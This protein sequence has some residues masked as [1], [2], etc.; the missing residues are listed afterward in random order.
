MTSNNTSIKNTNTNHKQYLSNFKEHLQLL[1]KS[2]NTIDSYMSDLNQYFSIYQEINR[3]N[4]QEYKIKISNLAA[5]SF[6]RKLTSLKQF[7]EYLLLERLI[8]EIV[9]YKQ[10]FI[11][12]QDKGNPTN[13]TESQVA[14]FLKKVNDKNHIYKSRN[15]AIIFLIANTGI[16][17]EEITNLL[18]KNLDLENGEL[19]LVKGKGNKQRVIL[20]NDKA[21]EVI[22]NW[23]ND[24]IIFK[25]AVNSPYLFVSEKSEKLHKNSI[26]DIFNLYYTDECKVKP[27]SL[28][29]NYGSA[30]QEQGILTLP[31]LQNQL[32]HSSLQVTSLYTHA[33]KDSIKKKINKLQI[34]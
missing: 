10:D 24:R 23:L 5:S 22:K 31:E 29:H 12:Q 28:R 11:R 14:E 32:G 13:V 19:L 21:I 16:R 34:G 17:R 33:R 30:T 25:K 9:V 8:G 6:N 20:L 2:Q 15:V 7:N 27:H 3:S 18:L 4:I 26:N 1:S